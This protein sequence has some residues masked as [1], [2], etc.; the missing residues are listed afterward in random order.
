[1]RF[2]P[3]MRVM[4]FFSR[5]CLSLSP[6]S[7]ALT[8]LDADP[9][10]IATLRASARLL[11]TIRATPGVYGEDIPC[12]SSDAALP[13]MALLESNLASESRLLRLAT[14][15]VLARFDPLKF[16]DDTGRLQGH[17]E[18]SSTVL[19]ENGGR[20]GACNFLEVAEALETLPISVAAERDLMWRLG[21]LEVLARSGRLP[22]PYAQLMATHALGLL[23]VKFSGVWPRATAIIAALCQRSHQRELVW[24]PMLEALRKVM[25]PPPTRQLHTGALSRRPAGAPGQQ[26]S[27]AGDNGS[28]P[29]SGMANGSKSTTAPESTQQSS[30]GNDREGDTRV[31]GSGPSLTAGSLEQLHSV[32][33]RVTTP[34]PLPW[35]PR[36]LPQAAALDAGPTEEMDLP[37]ALAGVFLDEPVRTGLQP[38]SGEVPLWASTD[39]DSTFAQVPPWNLIFVS[40]VP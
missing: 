16:E 15:R 12:I 24:R 7:R 39:A 27:V 32:S 22:R 1:M 6:L 17:R 9:A 36:L 20:D 34:P 30:S 40:R 28:A 38:E 25:P 23:R 13:V 18:G 19:R 26:T 3:C 37:V 21:Q 8:W 31:D 5:A 29:V 35:V 2:D 14:L 11:R 33:L 10:S 4:S